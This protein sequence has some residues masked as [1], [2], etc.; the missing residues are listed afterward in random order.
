MK[1]HPVFHISLL[2]L[3]NPNDNEEFIRPTTPQAIIIPETEEEEFEVESIL[4]KRII[5]NKPQYLVKWLGYP[6]YDATWEPL[7]N[8]HNAMKL[9]K[10]FESKY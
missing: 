6:L 7:E 1:I 3:Y 2:K 10:S 5:H 4:D 9:V 8:L